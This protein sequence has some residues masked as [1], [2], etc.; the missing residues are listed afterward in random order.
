MSALLEA[1]RKDLMFVHF[2]LFAFGTTAVLILAYWVC[3][4]VRLREF[5]PSKAELW[6]L[7]LLTLVWYTFITVPTAPQALWVLP[8]LMSV[9]LWALWRNRQVETRADAI[10]AFSEK[11]NAANYLLLLLIPLVASAIYFLALATDARLSTNRLVYRVATPV[12]AILWLVSVVT[13]A[14]KARL[15]V[16]GL[17]SEPDS[18]Q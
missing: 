10:V 15:S 3:Q 1:G 12:G 4:C 18:S 9:T 2:R 16:A 5:K 17:G 14:R 8:P 11:V 7:G 13:C 6:F